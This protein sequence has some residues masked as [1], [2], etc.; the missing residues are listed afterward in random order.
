MLPKYMKKNVMKQQ[1]INCK[2]IQPG[3]SNNLLWLS[4][5]TTYC[6]CNNLTSFCPIATHN[7]SFHFLHDQKLND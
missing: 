1:P 2:N 4:I 5:L 7:G 6:G 3:S